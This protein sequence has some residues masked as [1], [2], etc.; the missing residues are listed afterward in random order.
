MTCAARGN[1]RPNP[2]HHQTRCTQQLSSPW[3]QTHR[4][5]PPPVIWPDLAPTRAN[6]S[7]T[8]GLI[9][10]LQSMDDDSYYGCSHR[11]KRTRNHM[12]GERSS[13]SWSSSPFLRVRST[14]EESS[15]NPRPPQRRL[16][17]FDR[18][19]GIEL[20][21]IHRERY[22]GD[23]MDFRRPVASTSRNADMDVID[24]TAD[25]AG[26]SR[27]PEPIETA[28]I[29]ASRP[30]R[31]HREIIDVEHLDD[32]PGQSSSYRP[33]NTSQVPASPD[34]EFVSARTIDPPRRH[35]PN[36]NLR[37]ADIDLTDD[38]MLRAL[39]RHEHDER[40]DP[41]RTGALDLAYGRRMGNIMRM[42]SL[43]Q[44]FVGALAGGEL[45]RVMGMGG[46]V[47]APELRTGGRPRNIIQFAAPD[48]NFAAV[49]FDMGLE[50]ERPPPPPPTY[51]KPDPAP[52]GFTRSPVEDE[53]LICPNC[54]DEL[55]TGDSDL[56]KQVW[57]V[58]G[59]GHVYCGEC[60]TH[61]QLKGRKTKSR[62]TDNL[63]PAFKTCVAEG[64]DKKVHHKTSM[65]QVYL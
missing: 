36:P 10:P 32:V 40:D 16:P 4:H 9:E 24:L 48:L 63:P 30:P 33:E 31:Y 21:R 49:G 53:I 62:S 14:S 17:E 3:T 57:L 37:H 46:A 56:K 25:D 39:G 23:G 5:P 54:K 35:L 11:H 59:C 38:N 15:S 60:T 47:R 26:P 55:C 52:K 43:R 50:R 61:R 34:V 44:G 22:A 28:S 29:R 41:F 65:I 12:D 27:P 7:S 51:K 13:S 45:W 1:R 6:L 42:E 19:T 2:C 8:L 64:C 18:L 20:P 58:K